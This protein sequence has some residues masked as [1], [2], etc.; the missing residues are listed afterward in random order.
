MK[1]YLADLCAAD[2][3]DHLLFFFWMALVATKE[4]WKWDFERLFFFS[5]SQQ[6]HPSS[7]SIRFQTIIP[8]PAEFLFF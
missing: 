5:E 6:I 2:N 3:D 1:F 4:D 8:S 7:P